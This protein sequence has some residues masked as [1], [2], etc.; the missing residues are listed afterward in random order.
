MN[1][2]KYDVFGDKSEK[3]YEDGHVKFTRDGYY[4]E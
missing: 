1:K 2:D 4:F 3:Y